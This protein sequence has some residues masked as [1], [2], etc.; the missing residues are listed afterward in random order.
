MKVYK[1]ETG[2]LSVNTYVLALEGS[3]DAVAV[4]VGGDAEFIEAEC[5]KLGLTIK[6]VLLTH[7]HF[8]HIGGTEYF[9]K[10]GAKIYIGEKDAK[11]LS[12]KSLNLSMSFGKLIN[13]FN[14]D[15]TVKNGDIITVCG[16]TFKVLETP[17]HTVGSV[18]YIAENYL[19]SGDSLFDRCF[20]SYVFPTGNFNALISSLTRL[21][22]IEE[23]L[24]VLPGHGA[25]TCLI[26]EKENNPILNY[27]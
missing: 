15:Y 25:N 8:D 22:E 4:D 1:F 3:A 11:F 16:I 23:N 21:F 19:I 12:D 18:C 17:G 9:Q 14:A 13:S 27:L 5:K 7:G 24:I 26:E 2:L 20:G 10:K 6:A